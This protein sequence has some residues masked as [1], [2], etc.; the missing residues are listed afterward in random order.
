MTFVVITILLACLPVMAVSGRRAAWPPGL[1]VPRPRLVAAGGTYEG[2]HGHPSDAYVIQERLIAVADGGG[3]EHGPAAAALALSALVAAGPDR[4][5]AREADLEDRAARATAP[6]A[7]TRT[8]LVSTLDLIML[9]PGEN[10]CLRF[11]HV[12]NGAI[13]H[14]AK[15]ET[16]QPLTTSHSFDGGPP[17]RGI[18]PEVGTVPLRPGD[19][20]VIV[21]DGVIQAVGIPRMAELFTDG[22]SPAACLDRLYDEM[23]AV[24]PKDD[25]TV[26]IAEFVTV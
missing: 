18:A 26:V 2:S 20:V 24:E 14:V 1:P 21:T 16:P 23:A 19:R 22:S 4:T 13:W 12:G 8:G 7:P 25:A 5:G 6:R 3:G 17:P 15:G 11:A 9:D 10:P